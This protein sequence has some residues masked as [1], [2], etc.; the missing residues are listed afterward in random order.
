[1]TVNMDSEPCITRHRLLEDH[2]RRQQQAISSAVFAELSGLLTENPTIR[3]WLGLGA[4]HSAIEGTTINQ[5]DRRVQ[6]LMVR[7]T[8]RKAA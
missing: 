3:G 4:T 5:N 1:M 8:D 2:L 7:A 6:V